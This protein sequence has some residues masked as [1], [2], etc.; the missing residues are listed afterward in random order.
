MALPELCPG[1]TH[2]AVADMKKA[3]I[4]RLREAGHEALASKIDPTL[5]TY[6]K[7]AVAGVKQ[8]QRDNG[9]TED[10][11][12]GLRTWAAL[13]FQDTVEPVSQ[14]VLNGIPYTPG[15]VEVDGIW[16]AGPL[17]QEM[18]AQR[19]RRTWSGEAYSGY[20]PD[21]YQKRLFD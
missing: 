8:F 15:V 3:L 11:I 5:R 6:G 10:G 16:V 19:A 2:R 12:V 21:W 1:Q 14:P 4:A 13:G 20:R 17:A 18:L 7:H 9:L